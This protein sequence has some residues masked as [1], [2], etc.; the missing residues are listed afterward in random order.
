MVNTIHTH[1]FVQPLNGQPY[2]PTQTKTKNQVSFNDT[3]K[4]S[5]YKNNLT[6]LN[7]SKH[8]AKRMSER[9]IDIQPEQ[10]NR[11]YDRLQEAKAMGIKDSLVVTKK[12][13]MVVNA[14][15]NTVITIMNRGEADQHIF[16]NINGTIL[17]ND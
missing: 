12:E 9:N 3:L 14:Q 15:N 11:I 8:A 2:T 5:L 13:A 4:D 6:P 10:W 7:I 16:S 1:R 17:L